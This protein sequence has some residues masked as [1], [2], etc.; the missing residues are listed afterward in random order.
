MVCLPETETPADMC[1]HHGHSYTCLC[2]SCRLIVPIACTDFNDHPF[3]VA[4]R[5]EGGLQ[6]SPEEIK[7]RWDG[8]TQ[9]LR[10]GLTTWVYG[11]HVSHGPLSLAVQCGSTAGY[12][13]PAAVPFRQMLTYSSRAS[14]CCRAHRITTGASAYQCVFVRRTCQYIYIFA[15]LHG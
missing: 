14:A 15:L 1:A 7:F 8:L 4:A 6:T 2:A 9:W 5:G 10:R 11:T 3:P 12:R 13:I